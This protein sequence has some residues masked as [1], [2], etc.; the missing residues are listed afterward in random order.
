MDIPTIPGNP[1]AALSEELVEFFDQPL[2][3]FDHELLPSFEDT[4]EERANIASMY[5]ALE[6]TLDKTSNVTHKAKALAKQFNNATR[7]IRTLEQYQ[8][9]LEQNGMLGWKVKVRFLYLR[10]RILLSF[11]C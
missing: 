10:S 5:S 7:K 11:E 3:T 8:S 9:H 6:E 2:Y 1:T 4:E